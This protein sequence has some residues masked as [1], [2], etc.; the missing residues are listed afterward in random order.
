[1]MFKYNIY[2]W[3]FNHGNLA[4]YYFF[5]WCYNIANAFLPFYSALVAGLASSNHSW[6]SS[7]KPPG[8]VN[9]L[10]SLDLKSSSLSIQWSINMAKKESANPTYEIGEIAEWVEIAI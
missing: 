9:F 2:F 3:L 10:S 5:C 7:C 6:I 8:P 1:M 4:Y